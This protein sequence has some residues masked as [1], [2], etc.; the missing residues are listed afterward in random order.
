MPVAKSRATSSLSRG[1]RVDRFRNLGTIIDWT[2]DPDPSAL[3]NLGGGDGLQ[4]R[5]YIS[6]NSTGSTAAVARADSW[7]TPFRAHQHRISR[8]RAAGPRVRILLPP[9]VSLVRT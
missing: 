5:R 6:P 3:I 7:P 4:R 2:S 9:A 1:V 8:C